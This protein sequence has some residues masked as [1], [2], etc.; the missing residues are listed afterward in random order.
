MRWATAATIVLLLLASCANPLAAEP[1]P[2]PT[3]TPTCAQQAAPFLASMQSVAR[4][5]DD[6][7]KLADSTPRAALA[8]QVESLQT[9][10]RKAQDVAPPDCATAVKQALVDSMEATITGFISFLGQKT[11]VEVQA[12]FTVARQRMDLFT[13]E[14]SKLTG[15][16][17]PTATLPPTDTPTPT[18]VP[19]SPTPS[20]PQPITIEFHREITV[21]L[22][23][24]TEYP[25]VETLN[26]PGEMTILSVRTQGGAHWYHIQSSRVEGWAE[27]V[28]LDPAIISSLPVDTT[29]FSPIPSPTP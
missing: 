13:T 21:Y 6:A 5:W 25:K 4:E 29:K 9:I 20:G 11:D 27:I 10:R 7:V 26:N 23:P 24:G 14:L 15:I 8:A 19:A 17:L 18:D 28:G 2:M 3:P 1:T 16:P 12:A 22:G